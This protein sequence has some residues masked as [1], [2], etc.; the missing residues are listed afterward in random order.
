MSSR[1]HPIRN[2]TK[3]LSKH[4]AFSHRN[5]SKISAFYLKLILQEPF[6]VYENIKYDRRVKEHQ[7][8][9]DPVFIIGHWRSGTSFLQYLL[10]QD[11]QFGFMNKFQVVFP[12]V[13]LSSERFLKSIVNSIPRSLNLI[14]DAQNMS[15]NLELD[16][17]SE[18]EIALTTM[19][20]PTSLHWGHIFPNDAWE[21][22]DK[23]LF[24]DTAA[25]TD[26]EQW[27]RDY[28]YL[29]KKTSLQN[30]K[31]RLLIKSPGN[32]SRTNKLL[33]A[34]PDAQFIFIHR[35]PYDVFYSNKKLWNTLLNNL[36]LQDFGKEQIEEEILK[37][38][39]KLMG[40]YLEQR[41]DIPEGQLAEIRFEDFVSQPVRTIK[42][43]YEKFDLNGFEQAQP[44][45]NQFL[46]QKAEGKSSNYQYE[47]HI[48]E[49]INKH[50]E[51]AFKQWNY[52][53]NSSRRV[54]QTH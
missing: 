4:N 40:R 30:N 29:I 52:S 3:Q 35:N 41:S 25:K 5:L 22:F 23:Y 38:Y 51:F 7:L 48:I 9:E 53:I 20:S 1:R 31:R 45:F 13:F 2:L 14:R 19:I 28:H 34:Y 50:W 32:A 37:V 12:D 17:P 6:R 21:Y 36:A 18:I 10:G 26:I 44:Y 54:P 46:D 42:E 24:F 39:K 15:I 16:S 43:V 33:E 11:P 27:K 8:R 49:K 47:S